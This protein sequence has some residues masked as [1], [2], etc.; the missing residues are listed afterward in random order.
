VNQ[1]VRLYAFTTVNPD[2]IV[3]PEWQRFTHC[4]TYPNDTQGAFGLINDAAGNGC[5][6][7]I[8]GVQFELGNS[9]SSTLI[10]YATEETRG[11]DLLS[12]DMSAA[13][14]P[15]SFRAEITI[16]PVDTNLPSTAQ[17]SIL[18]TDDSRGAANEMLVQTGSAYNYSANGVFAIP[19]TE[20]NTGVAHK[21]EFESVQNGSNEDATIK[22]D[23][24][25]VYSASVAGTLDHSNLDILNVGGYDGKYSGL[26][27]ETKN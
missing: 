13:G 5:D 9:P 26:I 4:G 15:Q 24:I 19:Y 14:F 1:T 10:T 12:Y 18:R 8:W 16:S 11:A 7:S 6:V 21:W 2:I 25:I 17:L 3:T 23:G 20:L 27:I 22:Q